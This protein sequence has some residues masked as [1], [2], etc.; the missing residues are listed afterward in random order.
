MS[1]NSEQIDHMRWLHSLGHE[2]RCW[3]GWERIGKCYGR[4]NVDRPDRSH[5]DFLAAACPDCRTLP[6]NHVRG[7]PREGGA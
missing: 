2:A 3:C 6:P 7:C 4:C 5:A 1:F